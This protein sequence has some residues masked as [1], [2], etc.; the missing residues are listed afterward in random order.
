MVEVKESSIL[1][2][3]RLTSSLYN[4]WLESYFWLSLASV[5]GITLGVNSQLD[6][7]DYPMQIKRGIRFLINKTEL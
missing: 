2:W 4:L 5:M 1:T 7:C 3:L 6:F